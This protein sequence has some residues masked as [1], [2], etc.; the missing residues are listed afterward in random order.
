MIGNLSWTHITSKRLDSCWFPSFGFVTAGFNPTYD[1][2]TIANNYPKN[3]NKKKK[4]DISRYFQM[5]S[6]IHPDISIYFQMKSQLFARQTPSVKVKSPRWRRAASA[7]ARRATGGF[8]QVLCGGSNSESTA[9]P[10]HVANM[11]LKLI[12]NQFF[13]LDISLFSLFLILTSANVFL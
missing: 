10:Q 6:H 2:H 3:V 5:K 7:V 13:R 4:P 9:M 1:H 8:C 11:A 12:W